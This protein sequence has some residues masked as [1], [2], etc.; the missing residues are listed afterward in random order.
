MPIA[1]EM[2]GGAVP[3]L[4]NVGDLFTFKTSSKE[5]LYADKH[6]ALVGRARRIKHRDLF[7]IL[8]LHTSGVTLDRDLIGAKLDSLQLD[9]TT[10][11]GTLRQRADAGRQAILNGDYHAEMIRFLP[12]G[13]PWLF[14]ENRI[15]GMADAFRNVV[16]DNAR[17]L[18]VGLSRTV[19]VASR[20]A[21]RGQ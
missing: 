15:E 3:G 5:E 11:L 19:V 1:L 16:L 21:E 20:P 6:L 9:K 8:W 2:A 12:Q 7:D 14:D 13:S 18:D 4:G 10:F 17:S